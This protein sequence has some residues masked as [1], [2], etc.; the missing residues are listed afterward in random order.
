MTTKSCPSRHIHLAKQTIA[1]TSLQLAELS[2]WASGGLLVGVPGG[3]A[4][5]RPCPLR[6]IWTRR[7]TVHKEITIPNLLYCS[8]FSYYCPPTWSRGGWQSRWLPTKV[9]QCLFDTSNLPL[10]VN[11][12]PFDPYQASVKVYQAY[13]A[14]RQPAPQTTLVASAFFFSDSTIEFRIFMLHKKGCIPKTDII[15]IFCRF[16]K[17]KCSSLSSNHVHQLDFQYNNFLY[18]F[19]I[20]KKL[21]LYVNFCIPPC[22]K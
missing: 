20:V 10:V 6:L 14:G 3:R 19:C 15:L 5:R 1:R 8:N 12:C 16:Q 7:S 22:R 13:R 21:S 11:Q 2:Y 9:C 17:M 4:G 18:A